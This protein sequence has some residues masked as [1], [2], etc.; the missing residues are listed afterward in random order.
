ME[1]STSIDFNCL[2]L[3][4]CVE[5]WLV[6]IDFFSASASDSKKQT[7]NIN[8]QS[9]S[10]KESAE[11]NAT[12]LLANNTFFPSFFLSFFVLLIYHCFFTTGNAETNISIRS[13][14]VVLA[15]PELDIAKA[16][17]S[18]AEISIK[19][20]ENEQKEVEGKLGSM[21]LCDL[22]LHGQLY[23]ERFITTGKQALCFNYTRYV[24]V[25]DYRS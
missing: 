13:L 21:S 8:Y 14:T 20:F 4:I 15:K 22:T 7:S 23:R 10:S 5:S 18:N 11:G 25:S 3:V 24:I 2:D 17:I 1:R 6:V 12:L 16:N 19:T 9:Q